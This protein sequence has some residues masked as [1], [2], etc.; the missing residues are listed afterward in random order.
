MTSAIDWFGLA[1]IV[2]LLAGIGFGFRMA[3]GGRMKPSFRRV[4]FAILLVAFAVLVWN[5]VAGFR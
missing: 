1:I 4:Y 3:S 5:M 2:V